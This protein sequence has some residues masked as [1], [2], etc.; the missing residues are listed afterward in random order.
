[1]APVT[2][3]VRFLFA[4]IGMALAGNDAETDT[5]AAIKL[6]V[7]RSLATVKGSAGQG[8]P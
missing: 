8:S 5:S 4:G 3:I 2:A 6:H 7:S 1:V